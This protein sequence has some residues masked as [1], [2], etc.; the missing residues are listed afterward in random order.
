[1]RRR[2]GKADSLCEAG[3]LIMRM[4]EEHDC[5]PKL[6]AQLEGEIRVSVSHTLT[7][8]MFGIG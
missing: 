2:G 3:V 8:R 1:M 4:F 7:P 6:I 5:E